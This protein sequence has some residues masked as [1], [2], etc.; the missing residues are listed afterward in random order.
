MMFGRT[1]PLNA[2]FLI[3]KCFRFL[4]DEFNFDLIEFEG[5]GFAWSHWS[6][7]TID[8]MIKFNYGDEPQIVFFIFENGGNTVF[9]DYKLEPPCTTTNYEDVFKESSEWFKEQLP[10]ILLKYQL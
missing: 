6:N 2:R 1:N 4:Y 10:E 7:G 5:R 9:Y 3:V 8:I